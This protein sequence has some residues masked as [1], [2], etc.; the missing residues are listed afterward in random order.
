MILH[1]KYAGAFI[2]IAFFNVKYLVDNY[3]QTCSLKPLW[4]YNDQGI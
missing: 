1:I 3:V 4:L 2:I